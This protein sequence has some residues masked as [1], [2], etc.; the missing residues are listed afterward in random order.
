[1]DFSQGITPE[2]CTLVTVPAML[3]DAETVAA[4]INKLEVLYLSNR[5][6]NI[7]FSLLTDF[8][9]ALSKETIDDDV[10][11]ELTREGIRKL[12]ATYTQSDVQPFFL[13]HRSRQWNTKE[14]RWMGY[15]RK[16]GKLEALNKYLR[17][18]TIDPFLET[19]ALS[20]LPT[21][22]Y[23]ITLDSDTEL[24]RDCARHLIETMAHPLNTP[25]YDPVKRCI[26]KGYAIL[27]PRVVSSLPNVRASWYS[28]LF[29]SDS[30]IDPYTRAISDVYQ[31]LFGEGSFIGKGIY[32]VDMVTRVLADRLPENRILSHDLLEGTYCRS[33]LVSDLQ[34]VDEFPQRF[35]QDHSRRHR[36]IR[37]DWQIATWL[38][39]R[40]PGFTSQSA[41]QKTAHTTTNANN[42]DKPQYECRSNTGVKFVHN[43]LSLLS[44]WKIFDNLRRSVVPLAMLLL[45]ILCWFA[46]KP[47]WMGLA[48]VVVTL[49]VPGM[50]GTLLKALQIPP[51]YPF[52]IHI[53]M[54]MAELTIHLFQAF[55][56]LAIL[57]YEAISN[58]DALIRTNWRILF[59]HRNLLQW[60]V[61]NADSA[62]R[63]KGLW[64]Y[65]R[66]M[67]ASPLIAMGLGLILL[68]QQRI[69]VWLTLGLWFFSPLFAWWISKPLE[70]RHTN[71]TTKQLDHL[72]IIARKTWRYFEMFA[73][74][75]DNW[76]PADNYQESP[77]ETIAHRTS[78]TN[79]G[80]MLLS[81]LGAYDLGYL[82][83]GDLIDKTTKSFKSMALLERFRG[84]FFNWYD[85]TTLQ[86]LL[87]HYI[88]TVDSGN[89]AGYLLTLRTGLL[90]LRE[91]PIFNP[92]SYRGLLSTLRVL[93]GLV[94]A[95]GNKGSTIDLQIRSL[96]ALLRQFYLAPSGLTVTITNLYDLQVRITEM[97]KAFDQTLSIEVLW[98]YNALETQCDQLI[99]ELKY[100]APWL[101][102][103]QLEAIDPAAKQE[104]DL[105]RPLGEI[106]RL[107]KKPLHRQVDID[108]ST[109]H[110]ENE[111]DVNGDWCGTVKDQI[112]LGSHRAIERIGQIER[113]ALQCQ[114][115]ADQ[116]YEFLYDTSRKLLVI[117]YDV[118]K[119]RRDDGWYDL[120]ASE[121]RLGSFIGIAL[122]KLPIEH[123]FCLGR[124]ITI[125]R[126]KTMLLS[127]GGSMFEYL[128]PRLIMPGFE[129]TLLDQTC[130]AV[131]ERQI[132]YGQSRGVP[133]G[134]SE[135]AENSTDANLNYQYRSFG[136]PE[137]GLKRELTDDLV[138]APYASILALMFNPHE[139]CKNMQRFTDEG[140]EGRYGF[141][142]A[143]EFTPNRLST[144]YT[145]ALISS[146]M[147]HHQGMSLLSIVNFIT[148][149]P[150]TRRFG[151]DPLFQT[152][153]L[154]L[155]ER[156]PKATP[157][158]LP[159][160]NKIND[161]TTKTGIEDAPHSF[162]TPHT[163]IPEVHLL[164][165]GRYHV[166]V[167]N[168]GGGYSRWH[169][170]A[171]TRWNEDATMD[172]C[173]TF[174]YIN[175]LSKNK[176][177]SSGF[178]PLC[179]EP[180]DYDAEFPLARAEFRRSDNGFETFTEIAVSPEDDIEYRRI[181]LSNTTSGSRT[182]ELTSYAEVVLVTPSADS[183]HPAFSNLFLQTE[184]LQ[185]RHAILCSRRPRSPE[186]QSPWMFHLFTVR[187]LKHYNLS[188]E[189]DR[190]AFIG[191]GLTTRNPQAMVIDGPLG[192][193]DGSVLDPIVSIRCRLLLKAGESITVGFISG[194]APTRI[195]AEALID[196]YQ[197]QQLADRVFNLAVI[198]AKVM[199]R[200]LNATETDAQLYD[201]LAGSILYAS[202]YRRA[203]PALLLKN[204]RGQSNLWAYSISGD[205]PIILLRIG[206]PSKIEIVA[207]LILAHSYWRLKGLAVDLVIW[208]E[209]QTGYRQVFNDQII[210]LIAA[211][212]EASFYDKKGGIF[213]RHTDQISDED[214]VLIESVARMIFRDKDG[215]L[216]EQTR[217]P[218]TGE[219][220]MPKLVTSRGEEIPPSLEFFRQ[221][222]LLFFNGWGGFTADGKE[223]IIHIKPVA[224]PPMPW[225]NVVANKHFGTVISQSGGYSWFENAH[226]F[227]L[228]PWYND[229][230]TDRSGEAIYLRDENSGSYWSAT[231][232]PAP[233]NGDYLNRHGFGYSVFEYYQDYL[234]SELWV[235]VDVEA[236][237]K[238][239]LLKVRNDS[240]IVRKLS[241]TGFFELVL[242]DNPS[243]TRMHI[244]TGI[245]SKTGAFLASNPFTTE[246]KGHVVFVDSNGNDRSISGDR[247]EFIGRNGS[248]SDP[249]ALH[250]VRLSGKVGVG[251]DP[252]AA[253][254]VYFELEPGQEKEIVFILGVG[255]NID[256]ARSLVNQFR[257]ESRAYE[258]R[259]RVWS[260]WNNT[261]GAVTIDT[262][263]IALNLL[264]NGWLI[265]QVIAARLWAR[266]G[267][268]QSG[269]AFGF[270]DQ[271]QDVM[272]LVHT[273]PSL[274]REHILLCASRQF[275]EGDVQ[276]WWH[277][278]HGRGVRTMI[279]DDY[280]WLPFV[281]SEYV[282]RT[283][284]IG[285]LD[286]SIHFLDSRALKPGEESLYDLPVKTAE[287]K[288]LYEHCKCAVVHAL[289]YG[290]HGFPLMGSGDWN[291]G[292]NLV[293]IKGEGESVWLAFFL[294]AV[295]KRCIPLARMRDDTAF[296]S[297]CRE[298]ID[299]LQ[300]SIDAN[301]WDGAWYLRAYFDDGATIGSSKNEEC[302]IDAIAQSWSVLSEAGSHDRTSTAMHSLAAT[303]IDQ[304]NGL[305]KLFA[306]PFDKSTQEPGYIKGYVPGVRENGG[307]YTHAA[308]WTVMAFAKLARAEQVEAL[309]SMINPVN[310]GSTRE[311]ISRY[312]VE[313]Y[314]MAA[315]IYGSAPHAGRGG[316]TWYT[317]SA[318]WMYRLVIECVLGLQ[319]K[320]DILT[321]SPCIPPSWDHYSLQYRF[322]ETIYH[323]A[324]Q[325]N[326]SS[327]PLTVIIDGALQDDHSVKLKND[328]QDHFIQISIGLPLPL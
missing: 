38:L 9:D 111:R 256:D 295:L 132:D 28:R 167:T 227:R 42:I 183:A 129:H 70:P 86:P 231:P 76:L 24:P 173:G 235:F 97:K 17:F 154:L 244:R 49:L 246:F 300:H 218:F 320:A 274:I 159:T 4:L 310:H 146:F 55:F 321:F 56:S 37:G 126:G 20:A 226:E 74:S 182:I 313:P 298:N 260:F 1:M 234:K 197:D 299:L 138:I 18:S 109:M 147:A 142:E 61:P 64:T 118:T 323:L 65:Y 54:V 40:V 175:E 149:S 253:L 214:Q 141:Y 48:T 11:L 228:T 151:T 120:L 62:S 170:L 240:P 105:N 272:A 211:G 143:I 51:R 127:W 302:T 251:L 75:D 314:V 50:F 233:G 57:A 14:R 292:M 78:P 41:E 26:V 180:D 88:S 160:S 110:R 93:E 255:K 2:F 216:S 102:M 281:T 82:S 193:T 107:A 91:L 222:S 282:S 243:K 6:D 21:C 85:T 103:A 187:G 176:Q 83:A 220:L 278:P 177:W 19:E 326:N 140:Y 280:L 268:Y 289:R 245:D 135:S 312:L 285:V 192:G 172:N 121:S 108:Q 166:M 77:R 39:P 133:W 122:G 213:L 44:R 13:F 128:M 29:G 318:S 259:D 247:T 190:L 155:Q 290:K 212:P 73:G 200:Q 217:Y 277:P 181:T 104:L 137:L 165:N 194:I 10:L 52:T 191:R 196:K 71:I 106:A 265:Y 3:T 89:L 263:D 249:A 31:D 119:R 124:L 301:G 80:L 206:D 225:V 316:W 113:L 203:S 307:Q 305:I 34:L 242:G 239:M 236:P 296:A 319:L 169:D 16:R 303:L 254:Q 162:S 201:R 99:Q 69:D 308:V 184:I 271:L 324:F 131:V 232:L 96:S 287:K 30:G 72:H 186:E 215:S 315:D 123:W 273:Q 195:Q 81:H 325:K 47:A 221:E 63:N 229:P 145:P 27:Q 297:L 8:T 12:N 46:T 262:P 157:F 185:N 92:Q 252:A 293:G 43:P 33:G 248:L 279:S 261:L 98:W 171:V 68:M 204:T 327:T 237:V 168:A 304:P 15:E 230:I 112:E 158:L 7:Y 317:G 25:V 205:I 179:V 250:R 139:V 209:E 134:I 276:H 148:G 153:T 266:S 174:I 238:F 22:K 60:N 144:T 257:G 286:E 189:T 125:H 32:D 283:G 241:A 198:H 23:V 188:Y 5:A 161:R 35:S 309:L 207:K 288:N 59:S 45:I 291:D 275:P 322:R 94:I 114:E 67:G 202:R 66:L 152:T 115:F 219:P 58:T 53:R 101:I 210:G 79:I 164:S 130:E 156:I 224:P 136:V 328:R 84:H 306:P 163:T 258:A 267:Y 223:Y 269:G 284:D 100:L 178:Q 116:E 90:E 150:M 117:G 311:K 87:P 199:L 270:R 95:P 208:N 36:W 264:T 294:F